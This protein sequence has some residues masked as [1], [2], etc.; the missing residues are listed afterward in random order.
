MKKFSFS[1]KRLAYFQVPEMPNPEGEKPAE[2]REA[3]EKLA[4]LPQWREIERA[5]RSDDPEVQKKLGSFVKVID[6]MKNVVGLSNRGALL[7]KIPMP[8]GGVVEFDWSWKEGGSKDDTKQDILTVALRTNGERNK[9]GS[10]EV[11][12]GIAV[13]FQAHAHEGE[14]GRGK[15]TIERRAANQ[16]GVI[17]EESKGIFMKKGDTYKIRIEDTGSLIIVNYKN[18]EGADFASF[19]IV[20]PEE[21][22]NPLFMGLDRARN[23]LFHRFVLIYNREPG[24]DRKYSE[25]SGLKLTPSKPPHLPLEAPPV[26]K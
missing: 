24:G 1:E 16:P 17:L 23:L 11:L 21:E 9:A 2:K 8:S 26:K 5:Y 13:T 3:A 14:E 25:I 20:V 10:R 19:R 12:N 18:S 22:T 7:S 15:M 4:D 6:A